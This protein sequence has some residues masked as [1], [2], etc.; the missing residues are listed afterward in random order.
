MVIGSTD[1]IVLECNAINLQLIFSA[2]TRD[3]QGQLTLGGRIKRQRRHWEIAVSAMHKGAVVLTL[4]FAIAL[5][6]YE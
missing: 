3:S 2:C 1:V 4:W 6:E 5:T